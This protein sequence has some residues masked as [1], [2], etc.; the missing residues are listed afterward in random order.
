MKCPLRRNALGD[1][2]DCYKNECAW[3]DDGCFV[4]QTTAY[5][6][7][8][9]LAQIFSPGKLFTVSE[10]ADI[11]NVKLDRV[12]S[13]AREKILPAVCLGRQ[14]RFSSSAIEKF[15]GRLSESQFKK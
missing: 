5:E 12:Y 4:T 2:G 3:W 8:K 15:I 10:V 7:P 6:K 13:L 1:F 9:E 14:L 11:L